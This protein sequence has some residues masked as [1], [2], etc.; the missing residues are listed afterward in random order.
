MSDKNEPKRKVGRTKRTEAQKDPRAKEAKKTTATGRP[1]NA[2]KEKTEDRVERLLTEKE[3]KNDPLMAQLDC[4][5]DLEY[6]AFLLWSMMR[7][8]SKRLVAHAVGKSQPGI[9]YWEKR[10]QWKRRIKPTEKTHNIQAQVMYRERFY[11]KFGETEVKQIGMWLNTPVENKPVD[12]DIL[13]EVKKALKSSANNENRDEKKKTLSRHKDVVNAGIAYVLKQFNAGTL[14]A[15]LS[16][17]PKLIEMSLRLEG[18]EEQI[19]T[20]NAPMIVESMRVK[21]AREKGSNI[22]EAM[23]QDAE[24]LA[25]ILKN[26]KGTGEGVSVLHKEELERLGNEVLEKENSEMDSED[27]T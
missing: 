8:K 26:L 10:F 13:E 17:L 22:V 12:K 2:K 5:H 1:M 16:D 20:N 25:N 6:R 3:S 24:E 9:T 11:K 15:N 4:E 19:H 27:D 18:I 7:N 23:Y 21:Q 14:R